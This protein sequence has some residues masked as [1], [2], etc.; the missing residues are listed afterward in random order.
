MSK[1]TEKYLNYTIEVWQSYFP[2]KRTRE[3]ACEIADNVLGL[4]SLLIKTEH[5]DLINGAK[6]NER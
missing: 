1:Y 4:F 5:A 6:L 3:Q 2:E